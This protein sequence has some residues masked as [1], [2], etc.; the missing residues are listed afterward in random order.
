MEPRPPSRAVLS[1]FG[2]SGEPVL[3]TGG[4]GGTF[5]AGDAVLKPSTDAVLDEWTARVT[6][7]LTPHGFRVARPL[8]AGTAHVVDGWTAW[9]RVA[10]EHRLHGGPWREA[11]AVAGRFSAALRA[12]DRP[13]P[14]LPDTV[15]KQADRMAWDEIPPAWWGPGTEVLDRLQARKRPVA[16]AEQLVHGDLAGNLLWHPALPPAVIDLTPYRRPAGYASALLVVDAVVAYGADPGLVDEVADRADWDQLVLRALLFRL[17]TDDLFL[18]ESAPG[19]PASG[20]WGERDVHRR[21]ACA[22]PL[23]TWLDG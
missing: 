7:D 16:A 23:L 22:R 13:L 2:L 8:A 1:A 19:G 3:L 18:R 15:W 17:I 4:Q 5:T 6:T 20:R 21:M 14:E 11:L 9:E 10:G 12:V